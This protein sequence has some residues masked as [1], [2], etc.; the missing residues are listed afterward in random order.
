[1]IKNCHATMQETLLNAFNKL[2]CEETFPEKWK[3]A[4]IVPIPKPGKDSTQ[5]INYRPIALINCFTKLFER[6]IN[7]RIM[8]FLETNNIICRQQSGFRKNRG[9][10]DNIAQLEQDLNNAI[11][12]RSHTIAVFFDLAKAYDS[13]WRRGILKKLFESGLRGH[14]PIFIRNFLYDRKIRVRIGNTLSEEKT[15]PGG[16]MQGSVLSCTCFMIA[17]NGIN[18][19]LP[20]HVKASLYV[21]DYLIYASGQLPH[22]VERRVQN[23]LNELQKWSNR[24]GFT[25]SDDKCKSMH[26]CRRRG[27]LKNNINLTLYGKIMR[28]VEE[29]EFLGIIID[30]SL[31]WKPH[32]KELKR[33]CGKV[34]DLLKHL[35]YKEWGADRSSLLRLYIM[36]LKPRVDYGSESYCSAAKTTLAPIRTIQNAAIRIATG[37]LRSSPILSLHAESGILPQEYFHNIK[38]LNF[39]ARIYVNPTNPLHDLIPADRDDD[40]SEDEVLHRFPE[41]CFMSRAEELANKYNVNMNC[42]LPELYPRHPPWRTPVDVCRDL[43]DLRKRGR[44]PEQMKA[45]F[46]DHL[47]LNHTNSC[48]IYTDGS[49]TSHGVAF[50][51]LGAPFQSASRIHSFASVFTAELLAI[52]SAVVSVEDIAANDITIVT[53]S[54]SACLAL[55]T[56]CPK[57]ILISMIQNRIYS[58]EKQ[59][60]LCWVPSHVGVHMNERVDKLAKDAT[61]LPTISPLQIPKQDIKALIK[62]NVRHK[63]REKWLNTALNKYREISDNIIPLP[64]STSPCRSWEI[65]LCRLRLGHTKLTHGHLMRGQEPNFCDDCLV[66]MTVLHLLTECPTLADQRR[67]Y[68]RN[69]NPTIKNVLGSEFTRFNG[70]L[71]HF[72]KGNDLYEKI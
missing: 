14:L 65:I 40:D 69:R 16:I 28:S 67:Q 66:P 52:H 21:D 53:D 31:T 49:K 50:A 47:N 6:M 45:I 55:T 13:A 43:H 70:P 57:N 35:S 54:K 37:A 8:W 48:C 60:K 62:L 42:I 39:L 71:F 33:K 12:H 30:N 61:K 64:N 51:C 11:S 10:T 72:L 29:K 1:M 25:F 19:S 4:I 36:L 23:A 58:S 5:P 38:T 18:E 41:K 32:A 15:L 56:I 44:P 63:W 46:L 24:T 3:T 22:L 7:L 59:I 34:L 17:I 26:I 68:F 9:T 2:F 27:C 20:E